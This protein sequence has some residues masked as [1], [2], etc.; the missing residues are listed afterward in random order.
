MEN[1]KLYINAGVDDVKKYL[2]EFFQTINKIN[3]KI[4]ELYNKIG[5]E[6]KKNNYWNI[7]YDKLNIYS[8]YTINNKLINDYH[9]NMNVIIFL[10]FG[11]TKGNNIPINLKLELYEHSA[12]SNEINNFRNCLIVILIQNYILHLDSNIAL[13]L[14]KENENEDI[15]NN[16]IRIIKCSYIKKSIHVIKSLI[17]KEN[18]IKIEIFIPV[19]FYFIYEK[20]KSNFISFISSDNCEIK[21]EYKNILISEYSSFSYDE[22]GLMNF[23]SKIFEIKLSYSLLG[24]N[25]KDKKVTKFL[26][27]IKDKKF[28]GKLLSVFEKYYYEKYVKKE[29]I[30]NK[31]E[32]LINALN[33]VQLLKKNVKEIKNSVEELKDMQK[34]YMDDIFRILNIINK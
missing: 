33:Q 12:Y 31:N 7:I 34:N 28:K 26:E 20:Y 9:N 19:L 1:I 5:K 30:E 15:I 3:P 23:N 4:E 25:P 6:N 10:L 13:K 14:D 17:K 29:N 8:N 11:T 27:T 24:I 2:D 16:I 21:P 22:K 32:K 18:Q